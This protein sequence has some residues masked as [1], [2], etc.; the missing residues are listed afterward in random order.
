MIWANSCPIRSSYIWEK[1]CSKDDQGKCWVEGNTEIGNKI[2]KST[3]IMPQ[4]QRSWAVHHTLTQT[5]ERIQ[6][7]EHFSSWRAWRSSHQLQKI[8]YLPWGA[9]KG[10]F[11]L[12]VCMVASN[13]KWWLILVTACQALGSGLNLALESSGACWNFIGSDTYQHRHQL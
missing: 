1:K 11:C 10:F 8:S 7:L 13:L 5:L 4:F 2:L 3:C 12:F 9:M 6:Q